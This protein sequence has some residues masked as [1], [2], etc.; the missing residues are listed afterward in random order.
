MKTIT[1][2]NKLISIF[3]FLSMTLLCYSCSKSHEPEQQQPTPKNSYQVKFIAHPD[4]FSGEG[5]MGK[6]TGMLQELTPDGKIVSEVP[7]SSSAYEIS[8]GETNSNVEIRGNEFSIPE[9][10]NSK[11]FG[12][13]VTVIYGKAKGYKQ[14]VRVLRGGI[15]F[16][17][18]AEPIRF[19][20]KGGTGKVKGTM[21]YTDYY[22]KVVEERNLGD[23]NFGLKNIGS[24][25]GIDVDEQNKTFTVAAGGIATFTLQAS[26]GYGAP[27]IIE[28]KRE[29]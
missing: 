3:L 1:N 13:E 15:N 19:T 20:S 17:F 9:D 29:G 24:S 4:S 25:E 12:F 10:K 16:V 27:Q 11:E 28:I 2:A 6:I 8:I 22:G 21:Q 14:K 26:S 5:G 18:K 7:L 23:C